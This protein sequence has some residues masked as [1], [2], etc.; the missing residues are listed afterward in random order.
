MPD[1]LNPINGTSMENLKEGTIRK[2][3][4]FKKLGYNVVVQWECGFLQQLEI[5]PDMKPFVQNLK[6]Y[7]PLE[8]RHAFLGGRTNAVCLHK[9]VSEGQKLHYVDFTSLYPWK[10]KYCEIPID[11]PEILTSE[12]LVHRSPREGFG[13]AHFSVSSCPPIPSSRKIDVPLCKACA[14]NLQQSPCD[15]S[16]V[17]RVLSGTLCYIEINKALDLGY[18]MVRIVEVWHFPNT[19]YKLFTGYIDTL[20]KTKQEASGWPSRCATEQQKKQYIGEYE[21]KEGRN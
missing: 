2:I 5:N 14:E 7:T 1:T 3:E 11:H 6:F 20:L 17:D 12:E 8:P 13:T 15:H 9:E 4:R 19:S 10:N 16:D 18:S 21:R